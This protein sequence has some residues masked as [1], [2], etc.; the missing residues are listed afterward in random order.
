MLKAI[1]FDMDGVLV[2]STKHVWKS[3]NI[4]LKDEGVNFSRKYIRKNL[5]KS[6]RDLLKSWREEFGIR[7][8][9]VLDFSKKSGAIQLNLMKDEKPD[10][11]LLNLLEEAK[12]SSIKCVVATS[13]MKWRANEILQLLEISDY[14]DYVVTAE[15][16]KRHK[17][18]PEVFLEAARRINIKPEDCVVIEDAVDGVE[19][20][21]KGGMKAVGLITEYNSVE[22]I[23]QADLMIRNFSEISIAKLKKLFGKT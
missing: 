8:Y 3:F 20:A 1:I 18:H 7:E 6:L 10:K 23:K 5:G 15:D 2:N 13:S 14:F 22:E 19:A 12:R 9:D 17:P 16:T 4:L 21:H 11:D